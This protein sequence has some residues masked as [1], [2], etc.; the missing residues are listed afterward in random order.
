MRTA[1]HRPEDISNDCNVRPVY[2]AFSQQRDF[3]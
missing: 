1:F 3:A 2:Q